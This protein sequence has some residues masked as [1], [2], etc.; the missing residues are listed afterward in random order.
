M[1]YLFDT[2]TDTDTD[3][4]IDLAWPR[5]GYRDRYRDRLLVVEYRS[6]RI[7]A[8]RRMPLTSVVSELIYAS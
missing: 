6:D 5:Y 8:N 1:I 7:A 4:D 3:T 2:D